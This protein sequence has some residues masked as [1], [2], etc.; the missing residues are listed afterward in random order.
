MHCV[1][2]F[3][4]IFVA[5]ILAPQAAFSVFV[6]PPS[7]SAGV[8]EKQI[9]R[10]YDGKKVEPQRDV[11]LLEV[12][13]PQDQLDIGN[14]E[15]A[16]IDTIQLVG[17][18]TLSMKEIQA[19]IAP[20]EHRELMMRE[21]RE[22][23]MKLQQ[24]YVSAGYFLAR[25][26]PPV[27]EIAEGMLTLEVLEGRLGTISIQGE[28][29]YKESFIRKHLA[30]F[31]G[32]AVNYDDLLRALFLLNENSDLHVGAVFKKGSEVG[33]A[34]LIVQ[35]ED[36]RP[37]H[38]YIDENNYGAQNTTVWRTGGKFDYGNLFTDGDTLSVTEVIGN[39]ANALIYTNASYEIPL[40]T[41]GTSMKMGYVYSSFH[42]NQM[43]FLNLRGRTQIASVE[44]MQALNRNRNLST[45]VYLSFEYEQIVNYQLNRKSSYDKLRVLTAG[46]DFDYTDACKGRNTGDLYYTLGIPNF[47]GGLK[48][49]DPLA[50]RVGSGGAFSILNFDYTRMQTLPLSCFVM[51][52]FSG[53][54][55]PYKLPISEQF[56][57]G[58]V[59]TVRGFP[60]ASALGD[61]GYYA[62]LEFRAPI[63]GLTDQKFPGSSR[64]WKEWIQLVGFVDQGGVLLNGGGENQQHHISMTGAGVGIRLFGPYRFNVSF[65]V[66]FPL[67]GTNQTH[68]PV[69]YLKAAVQPF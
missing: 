44:V 19:I 59:D 47:L 61:D 33:T 57:I 23:C 16:W 30:K 31:Q 39:P 43:K 48:P 7:N 62:N 25:V 4:M 17:N 8:V 6:G 51:L 2:R 37:C 26:F 64:A 3:L 49:V 29:Y 9:E 67:T 46:F 56:Y 60:M 53:Q 69:Y 12:D 14:N 10:E 5:L 20:Y 58:G 35:V 50:S 22:L 36:K 66:A 45:D 40:N 63:P 11:P 21:I 15:R 27:Q 34:D 52:H 32:K 18:T 55:T 68:S 1:S 41:W 13:L 65:D 28:K 42:V 24:A 38:L 54:A